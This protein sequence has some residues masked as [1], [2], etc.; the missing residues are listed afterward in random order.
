MA[1]KS[2]RKHRFLRALSSA[3]VVAGFVAMLAVPSPTIGGE[4]IKDLNFQNADVRSVLNFLA[5]YG[6]VNLVA[7]PTVQGQVTLKLDNVEWRQA[8]DILAKT[9]NLKVVDEEEGFLRVLLLEDF[10]KEEADRERHLAEQRQLV[11]L[12]TELFDIKFANAK[13][14][15]SPVK[16]LLSV[17]GKIDIE[18]RTN[19]LVISDEPK[20]LR[21]ITKYVKALDRET[22]QVRISAKLV[23]VS[24]D[25]FQEFGVSLGLIG[26]GE[27]SR[28]NTY[29]NNGSTDGSS[30]LTDNFGKFKFFT[31]QPGWNL[32]A[33]IAALVSNGNARILAHPVITTVDNMTARIQ[34]GQKVPIKQFSISGDVVIKFEEVG[35][36]LNVTPHITSG[37]RILL[38]LVTERSSFFFDPSGVVINTSNAETNVV[39]E[40]GQTAVIA[41]L[42]TDDEVVTV[43]GVPFLKDIPLLG[44]LFRYEKTDIKKRDLII[45]V[46]PEIVEPAL[47]GSIE[48]IEQGQM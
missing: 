25:F 23:E 38:H 30:R 29:S 18:V 8:L 22:R 4:I 14:L 13:D 28:G 24:T 17:R 37:N 40:S 5:E 15:I 44:R 21:R 27:D 46:T 11:D 10:I 7:A 48:S 2:L 32:D 33:T 39:V 19:T 16:S 36:I 35:T 42:T 1:M 20:N 9:Y 41:G 45:F 31:Q 3:F 26:S 47:M 43:V 34:V 12:E 6:G